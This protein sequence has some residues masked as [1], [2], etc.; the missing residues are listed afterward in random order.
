MSDP[1]PKRKATD[2]AGIAALITAIGGVATLLINQSHNEE[3]AAL[4]QD[5][6][7]AVLQYRLEELE[8]QVDGLEHLV[9]ELRIDLARGSGGV[10]PVEPVA[11]VVAEP[12][13]PAD[14]T[15]LEDVVNK[16]RAKKAIRASDLRDLVQQTGRGLEAEDLAK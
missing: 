10:E 13:P 16:V 14:P 6:V 1:K 5:S 9:S 8:D 2:Y 3:K 11:A 15:A 7:L 4:V 12:P